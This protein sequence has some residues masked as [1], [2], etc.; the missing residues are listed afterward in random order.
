MLAMAAMPLAAGH[1]PNLSGPLL[2]PNRYRIAQPLLN[3]SIIAPCHQLELFAEV[4]QAL[5]HHPFPVVP[6][7]VRLGV[8]LQGTVLQSTLLQIQCSRCISHTAEWGTCHHA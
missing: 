4:C 8:F 3:R 2:G 6:A 7:G 5:H 1:T